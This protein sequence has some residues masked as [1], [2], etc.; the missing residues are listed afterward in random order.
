[1]HNFFFARRVFV[2]ALI[3]GAVIFGTSARAAEKWLRLK[4]ANFDMLSCGNERDSTQ[5]LV[6]LEQFRTFFFSLFHAG[7]AHDIRPLI[8][9]FSNQKQFEKYA[10]R[11]PNGKAKELSGIFLNSF[12]EHRIAMVYQKDGGELGTIFH[13]YVHALVQ[14]RVSGGIP[15]WFNEGIAEVYSTFEVK[16]D[17]IK[18]G[19]AHGDHV[20]RLQN[21]PLIP[22]STF[23]A[24]DHD[25]PYYNEELKMNAYYAQAWA[26]MHFIVC[27]QNSG[28]ATGDSLQKFIDLYDKP[29]VTAQE[30]FEQ[31]FGMDYKTL[32]GL[33]RKYMNT[34][35]YRTVVGKVPAKS[36]REKITM[37][38]ATQAECDVELAGLLWRVHMSPHS[39]FAL[40]QMQEK[41]PDEPRLHE[42]F[43]EIK[44]LASEPGDAAEYHRKAIEKDSRNAL[45]YVWR[46]RDEFRG[47]NYPLG[48]VLPQERC[49]QYRSLADKALELSPDCM[50]AYELLAMVESLSEKMRIAEI[51]KVLKALPHMRERTKTYLALATV[52][53][54][55]K[56]YEEAETVILTLNAVS[57]PDYHEKWMA[58][59]L[60]R[61]IAKDSGKPP[62]PPM[63]FE[64]LQ[65]EPV[66]KPMRIPAVSPK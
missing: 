54:R 13:E 1:M 45:V 9:V 29:G 49:E 27:G 55:L 7:R 65:S 61:R 8:F 20:F 51:N 5:M 38:P 22:L 44:M 36:I 12:T 35:R 2:T 28:A 18:F 3:A 59:E 60:L 47:A 62:P 11:L 14:A 30:A 16:G 46:L 37:R 53:W 50:E 10:P 6:E 15:L 23:F 24:V 26:L 34:G 66:F 21:T 41:Y 4:S 32:E 42:I 56:R 39:E 64:A 17:D 25:S 33:L 52:Y 63:S 31:A 57:N 40:R 48:Y 19:K 58:H 43:A